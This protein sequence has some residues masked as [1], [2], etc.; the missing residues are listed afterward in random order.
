[1]KTP[2]HNAVY[3]LAL[4]ASIAVLE[5]AYYFP[6]VAPADNL[7]AALLFSLL[8]SWSPEGTLLGLL[9]GW[10]EMREAP[11]P[12]PAKKIALA[13][14]I[15]STAG[16]VAWQTFVH[17]V[18][19]Q[20]F[21]LSVLRDYMGQPVDVAGIVLYHVW[22]MLVFGGLASAAWFWQQRNACMLAR[23]RAAEVAREGTQ[24]HLAQMQLDA[25]RARIDPDFVFHTLGKLEHLYETEPSEAGR[26]L[27]SFIAYLRD[28]LARIRAAQT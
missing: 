21:G 13:V 9:T 18:L 17:L 7:G 28:A 25:L 23:L 16:V 14:L 4:G 6:L 8:V 20:R 26:L 2:W 22:L 11:R 5:F 10:L 3:G 15:A 27:E 24:A 12:L 19:R 1:M